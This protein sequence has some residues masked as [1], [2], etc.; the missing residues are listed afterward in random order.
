MARRHATPKGYVDFT[1]EEESE[2]DANE[3]TYEGAYI[4]AAPERERAEAEAVVNST[5]VSQL[6]DILEASGVTLHMPN[7]MAQANARRKP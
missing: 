2:A 5:T 6:I 1:P 7:E 4:A 3:A